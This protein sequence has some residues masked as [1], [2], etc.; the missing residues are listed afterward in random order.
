MSQRPF[1]PPLNLPPPVSFNLSQL[2]P[3][4]TKIFLLVR[5]G[6]L[7]KVTRTYEKDIYPYGITGPGCGNGADGL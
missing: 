1:S 6:L 7:V 2:A 3:R 4:I 5:Q